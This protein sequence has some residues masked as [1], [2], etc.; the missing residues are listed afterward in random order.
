MNKAEQILKYLRD[1]NDDLQ[2]EIE[3]DTELI[4]SGIVDS[5]S[6]TSLVLYLEELFGVEIDID[7]RTLRA[8]TSVR[9]MINAFERQAR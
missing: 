9:A 1:S 8:L 6:I 4:K 7:E 3:L 2:N 5:F